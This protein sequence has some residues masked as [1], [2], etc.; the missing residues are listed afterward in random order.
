M[1]ENLNSEDTGK[2]RV[3][4]DKI[5]NR[6]YF[7][8]TQWVAMFLVCLNG[9][10]QICNINVAQPYYNNKWYELQCRRIYRCCLWEYS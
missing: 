3:Q 6:P 5:F 1:V 10:L 9:T 2:L 4:I 8:V 7:I